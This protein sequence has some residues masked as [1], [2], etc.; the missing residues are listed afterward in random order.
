MGRE[1]LIPLTL[2]EHRELGSE[3]Q[4]TTA[5]LRSLCDLVIQVYGPHNLAAFN[6]LKAMEAVDRV[7]LE[8]QAQAVHD[9]PG[10]ENDIFYGKT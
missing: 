9:L 8:L 6:F 2:D 10:H 3:M 1:N 7:N 4:A 5:R